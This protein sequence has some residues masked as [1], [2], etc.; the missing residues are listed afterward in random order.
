M[1]LRR[2]K[3]EGCYLDRAVRLIRRLSVPM[4]NVVDMFKQKRTIEHPPIGRLAFA[5]GSW[6]TKTPPPPVDG[7]GLLRFDAGEEAPS[8]AQLDA[9]SAL[10]ARYGELLPAISARLFIEYQAAQPGYDLLPVV[11][12]AGMP[13]VTR[14]VALLINRDCSM[15]L[16]YELYFYHA[17]SQALEREEH[18]LNV[19]LRGTDVAD[20]LFEG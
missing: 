3:R 1:A 20:V 7:G 16:S 5:D 10:A 13:G 8:Q 4:R 17:A 19:V 6:Q 2:A 14:L 11:S 9:F 12:S 18:Q 15:V